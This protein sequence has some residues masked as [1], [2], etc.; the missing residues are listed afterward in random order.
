MWYWWMSSH[1]YLKL[2][3]IGFGIKIK[4]K[5][6]NKIRKVTK[7]FF[8][9]HQ[10]I[11][12]QLKYLLRIHG[13]KSVHVVYLRA[14]PVFHKRKNVTGKGG[15]II[16]IQINNFRIEK[17]FLIVLK[18]IN[19]KNKKFNSTPQTSKNHDNITLN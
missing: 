16:C 6:T 19:N 13:S 7:Y 11:V 5:K 3:I 9:F 15:C 10:T 4:K 1:N 18:L 12:R 14:I 8:L 2:N 17:L